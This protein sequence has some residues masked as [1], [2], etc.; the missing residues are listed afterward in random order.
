VPC[1]DRAEI[2]ASTRCPKCGAPAGVACIHVPA[3]PRHRIHPARQMAFETAG[4]WRMVE[5]NS[6]IAKAVRRKR[7]QQRWK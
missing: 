1:C 3:G 4:G 5:P 6:S 2:I 7:H